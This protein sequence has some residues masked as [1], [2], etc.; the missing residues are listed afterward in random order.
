MIKKPQVVLHEADES[1]AIV[2]L[3]D[4]DVLAG[5]HC[6]EIGLLSSFLFQLKTKNVRGQLRF[7]ACRCPCPTTSIATIS[8]DDRLLFTELGNR[9]DFGAG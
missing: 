4:A 8:F 2:D 6:A 1:V 9:D 3:L 7:S 5:E